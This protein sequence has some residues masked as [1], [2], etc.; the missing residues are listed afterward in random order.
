MPKSAFNAIENNISNILG[1]AKVALLENKGETSDAEP[2]KTG[3]MVFPL[4]L[5]ST[6][7]HFTA[8]RDLSLIHI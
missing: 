7:Y 5:A 4:K 3:K 1:G 6:A 8:Q 2:E